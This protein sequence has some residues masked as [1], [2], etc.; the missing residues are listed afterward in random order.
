MTTDQA[1]KLLAMLITEA[2]LRACGRHGEADEVC[3][4]IIRER[5]RHAEERDAA[6]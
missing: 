6:V 4:D 3:R 2:W 1:K 5:R